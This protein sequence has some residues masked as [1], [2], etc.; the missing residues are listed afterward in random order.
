MKKNRPSNKTSTTGKETRSQVKRHR[1]Q[2]A[3]QTGPRSIGL[4]GI[5]LLHQQRKVQLSPVSAVLKS[6]PS[7]T[8]EN[9]MEVPQKN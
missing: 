6:Q 9:S 7:A 5:S 2:R 3:P 4:A 8:M 1:T